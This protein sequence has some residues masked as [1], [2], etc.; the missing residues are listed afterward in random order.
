MRVNRATRTLF[1]HNPKAAGLSVAAWLEQFHGYQQAVPD[2]NA[3]VCTHCDLIWLHA[4]EPPPEFNDFRAWCVIR[5][6]LA[7]WGSCWNYT[8]EY[9][10]QPP[11]CTFEEFTVNC[12]DWLPPQMN[13]VR[14]CCQAV[15]METLAEGLAMMG[16][17]H[18]ADLPMINVTGR[19]VPWTKALRLFVRD[20]FKDDVK[21]L[22]Y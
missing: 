19:P 5:E 12:I 18:T 16:F 20:H 8:C 9:N 10:H 4:W 6:P 2:L 14:R 11:G 17:E 22:G 1:L 3:K 21:H 13:Y 7:R 15:R